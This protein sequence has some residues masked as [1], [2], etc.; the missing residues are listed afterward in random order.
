MDNKTID[1]VMICPNCNSD[2]TYS[3]STDEIEF[4]YDGTGHY[5]VDCKC[6]KCNN[7]FR[8]YMRF[9]YNITQAY[10]R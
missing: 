2:D 5:F 3:Y 4:S 6:N 1:D 7:N 8:L 9:N 10:T